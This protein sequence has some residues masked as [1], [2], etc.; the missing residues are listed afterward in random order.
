MVRPTGFEHSPDRQLAKNNLF[1]Q[2][3]N[4]QERALSPTGRLGE[5]YKYY[6]HQP[7]SSG[8]FEKK[9]KAIQRI[10]GMS[11]LL[12]KTPPRILSYP[13]KYKIP[14]TLLQFSKGCQ[15]GT[16]GCGSIGSIHSCKEFRSFR[17]SVLQRALH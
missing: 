16:A 4:K 13:T 3:R 11:A 6:A 9:K 1:R 17:P 5:S 2:P 14:W 15:S 10:C 7:R 12:A 8:H